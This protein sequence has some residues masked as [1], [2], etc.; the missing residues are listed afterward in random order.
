MF[1]NTGNFKF[2]VVIFGNGICALSLVCLQDTNYL[3]AKDGQEHVYHSVHM[4]LLCTTQTCHS[5][6]RL[7]P[8]SIPTSA[9]MYENH[10]SQIYCGKS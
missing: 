9:G 2:V 6:Y 10:W 5:S 7:C 4:P 8:T 3:N 1:T